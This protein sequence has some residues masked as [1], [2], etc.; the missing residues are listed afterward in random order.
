MARQEDSKKELFKNWANA[1]ARTSGLGA[2]TGYAV[3]GGG[4][5][6][7]NPCGDGE[8]NHMREKCD[9]GPLNGQMPADDCVWRG[10]IRGTWVHECDCYSID[11]WMQWCGINCKQRW[12]MC[13]RSCGDGI[14]TDGEECDDMNREVGDGCDS[15]CILETECGNGIVEGLEQC[16]DG[17][18]TLTCDYDCTYV[19]CGDGYL[20]MAVD[21]ECDL[22]VEN[23]NLPNALC[24]TNCTSQD[25]GD[26]IVDDAFVEE[27]DDGNDI[28]EDG[29]NSDCKEEYCGDGEIQPGLGEQCEPPDSD[30]C[31]PDCLAALPASCG[32]GV[33]EAPEDCEGDDLGGATCESLGHIS[34]GSLSCDPACYFDKSACI[35]NPS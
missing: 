11:V 5:L 33:I 14:I 21:E 27:C 22:G 4:K 25:C 19:E 10:T 31:S 20:N 28:D 16:D 35:P 8:V 13:E 1:G 26:G 2:L 17:A 6:W 3:Y 18:D 29:C 12:V 30:G 23:S 9:W 7:E 15:T 32:D 24:R 34:G